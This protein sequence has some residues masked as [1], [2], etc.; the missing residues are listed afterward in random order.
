MLKIEVFVWPT[1]NCFEQY[2]FPA[3]FWNEFEK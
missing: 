2:S 3:R 1:V